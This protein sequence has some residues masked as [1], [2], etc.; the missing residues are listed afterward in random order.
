MQRAIPPV[1]VE[2]R[3]D[4]ARLLDLDQR[5]PRA[6]GMDRPRRH[7]K[8]IA[9]PRLDPVEPVLDRAVRRGRSQVRLAHSVLEAESELRPRLG[10]DH[11]P[12][13]ALAVGEAAGAGVGVVGVDLDRQFV[14]GEQIFD[15][16]RQSA[17]IRRLEPDLADPP[18][19][20]VVPPP[21][22]LDLARRQ[23]HSPCSSAKAAAAPYR[24]GWG[25]V[26]I[27]TG[28]S[29]MRRSNR[30]LAMK[31]PRKPEAGRRSASLRPSPPPITTASA[32]CA[33]AISPAT[34][35]SDR[36]KRSNAAAARLSSPASAACQSA[37]SSRWRGGWPPI[38]PGIP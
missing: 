25:W 34:E 17:P 8:E 3:G 9:L 20:A 15:E 7:R 16:E 4:V 6:D 29:A 32:P 27:L 12:A 24:P 21:R 28:I 23:L 19:G 5:Q 11:I 26:R 37:L 31:R 1:I 36:Q 13:F 33:S 14:A 35:P 18:A 22:L 38:P 2:A 30:P 10:G